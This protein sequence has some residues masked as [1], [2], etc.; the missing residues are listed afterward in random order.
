MTPHLKRRMA[1]SLQNYVK[2]YTEE[3]LTE[4]DVHHAFQYGAA[5]MYREL[6]P[7]KK[8]L[9]EIVSDDGW[10]EGE[11]I[12]GPNKGKS[13]LEIARAALAKLE[14]DK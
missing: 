10:V 6:E 13:W 11:R 4:L 12:D 1:E 2:A 5:A 7:L 14:G 3:T 8:A 9:Q